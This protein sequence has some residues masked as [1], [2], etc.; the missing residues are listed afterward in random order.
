[1]TNMVCERLGIT[2]PILQGPMAWASY[3]HL[4]AAVSNAGGLGIMGMG[5]APPDVAR[6][7]IRKTKDL[8]D[9]P[10]GFNAY[11]FLPQID[12]ICDVI[13]GEQ[14]AVVAV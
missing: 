12:A 3:S 2:H 11:A 4:A 10:F 7:E 1:M 14:V 13:V 9:R 8:T 6:A 5:T